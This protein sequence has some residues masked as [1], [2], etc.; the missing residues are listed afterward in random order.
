MGSARDRS[1]PSLDPVAGAAPRA[2]LFAHRMLASAP[3]TDMPL[4]PGRIAAAGASARPG[5]QR[6]P[7]VQPWGYTDSAYTP[8]RIGFLA[9]T[10]REGRA[11]PTTVPW[12][13]MRRQCQR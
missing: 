7:A 1:T 8:E 13:F 9:I 5:C 3:H 2:L 11:N 6:T 4:P 12:G 10:A